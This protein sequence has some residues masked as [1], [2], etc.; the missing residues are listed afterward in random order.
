M[1]CDELRPCSNCARHGVLCSLVNAESQPLAGASSGSS[2]LHKGPKQPASEAFVI[3]ND[4]TTPSSS[5]HTDHALNTPTTSSGEGTSTSAISEGSSPASQPDQFPFLSRFLHRPEA[6]QSDIWVMDL[7]L[8]HHWST[9]AHEVLSLRDDMRHAWRVETPKHAVAHTFLMHEILAFSAFHKAFQS[10]DQGPGYYTCGIH[11]QDLAIRGVRERLHNVKPHE[12][13]AILA[14]ST[15]LTL[16]VFASTGFEAGQP[17]AD[18]SSSAVEDILNIFSLM[19]GMGHVL[20]IAYQFVMGSFLAPMLSDS[21]E[22]TPAQPLL[23]D[24]G[25]LLPALTTFVQN[26]QDLDASERTTYLEAIASLRAT[27]A[28][29]TPPKVDNRELRFLFNW[30]LRLKPTFLTY[31]RQQRPGALAIL[32]HYVT[33][34]F[35]AEPRYWYLRGWGDRLMRSCFNGVDETWTPVMQ[36]PMSF[37][38]LAATNEA[39]PTM[40]PARS[41]D[42]R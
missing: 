35:V 14:T 34:F 4:S 30:S 13:T 20:A 22:D 41:I 24:L 38:N 33:M 31:M 7:E 37:L 40:E 19:Q 8:M 28:I 11:H 39:F 6:I 2:N 36:W 17:L 25:E 5:L 3:R 12:A 42:S 16:S 9:E 23:Q 26:K 10:L 21:E 1:K 15:L 27:L 18:S 32:S 29:A